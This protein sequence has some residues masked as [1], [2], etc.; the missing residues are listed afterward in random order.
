MQ[1]QD[2]KPRLM[3]RVRAGLIECVPFIPLIP[4]IA[5]VVWTVWTVLT[6]HSVVE[7]L[8]DWYTTSGVPALFAPVETLVP[9]IV[10]FAT[11]LKYLK[12]R[13]PPVLAT[14][15]ITLSTGIAV[16]IPIWTHS[17]TGLIISGATHL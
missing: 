5:V 14:L 15:L 8:V 9:A 12:A 10:L 11:T 3:A 4:T 16:F 13:Q 17:I 7:F 1:E 2:P 6:G